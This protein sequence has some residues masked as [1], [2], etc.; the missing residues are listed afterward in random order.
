MLK[1]TLIFLGS[2]LGGVL[3]YALQGWVQRA[4]G[5]SFPTGTLA[6]NVLGRPLAFWPR[7]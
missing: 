6:V 1:V 2:G 5:G 4:S 7:R 3:R